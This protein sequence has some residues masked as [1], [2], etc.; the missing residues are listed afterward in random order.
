MTLKQPAKKPRRKVQPKLTANHRPSKSTKKLQRKHPPKSNRTVKVAKLIG[1]SDSSIL[2]DS[3][4]ADSLAMSSEYSHTTEMSPGS[5]QLED[6]Q[7]FDT[8]LFDSQQQDNLMLRPTTE[9]E[10]NGPSDILSDNIAIRRNGMNADDTLFQDSPK[11]TNITSWPLIESVQTSVITTPKISKQV[12]EMGPPMLLSN[13]LLSGTDREMKER[14]SPLNRASRIPKPKPMKPRET[15]PRE[16]KTRELKSREP[17][18]GLSKVFRPSYSIESII[19]SSLNQNNMDVTGRSSPTHLTLSEDPMFSP[20]QSVLSSTPNSNLNSEH[21]HSPS[22]VSVNS[23]DNILSPTRRPWPGIATTSSESF[24]SPLNSH[25]SSRI[26]SPPF[27]PTSVSPHIVSPHRPSQ[28]SVF[29]FDRPP[30][31]QLLHSSITSPRLSPLSPF[32]QTSQ[33][34]QSLTFSRPP[35]ELDQ[36]QSNENDLFLDSLIEKEQSMFGHH[37]HQSSDPS[38][39]DLRLR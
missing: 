6:L 7:H 31:S 27:S 23:I 33:V 25:A 32:L 30:S 11:T 4:S 37:F 29:N 5:P 28:G 13:H 10:E 8:P 16:L 17:K 1:F 39:G 15:K 14:S 19:A 22:R 34:K 12:S 35:E 24:S 9:V 26:T 21:L 36:R 20:P 2:D 3:F 18:K 38:L